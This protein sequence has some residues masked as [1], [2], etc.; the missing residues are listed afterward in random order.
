MDK[1]DTPRPPRPPRPCPRPHPGPARWRPAQPA[2]SRTVLPR[3]RPRAAASPA[4]PPG[5]TPGTRPLRRRPRRRGDAQVHLA[6]GP[7]GRP[8][9][10][11]PGLPRRCAGPG[12]G[13]PRAQ[14]R[15]LPGYATELD[16][17][18]TDGRANLAEARRVPTYT[19]PDCGG[20]GT[21]PTHWP[22][23][24]RLYIGS[25]LAHRPRR[26][27]ARAALAAYD[28]L[29]AIPGSA[30]TTRPGSS[31][32]RRCSATSSARSWPRSMSRPERRHDR[33]RHRAAYIEGLLQLAGAL[34]EHEEIQLPSDGLT[35]P[36]G[37]TFWAMTPAAGWRLPPARSRARHGTR[38]SAR[39]SC[40]WP[41]SWPDSRSS[42]SPSATPCA[43]AW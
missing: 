1:P 7:R 27:G 8:A 29:A 43:P 38:P 36:L 15:L 9:G 3:G 19:C 23:C 24:W 18:E 26:H 2:M 22:P 35:L 28:E 14:H 34:E 10:S 41:A 37:F 17:T 32:R 13:Q 40:G 6:A 20:T 11:R 33:R 12:P 5:A 16:G 30:A 31:P 21:E 25:R 42:W 39:A 4:W